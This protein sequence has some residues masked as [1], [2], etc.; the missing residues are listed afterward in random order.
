MSIRT[1]L[2]CAARSCVKMPSAMSLASWRP[3]M[4]VRR[5]PDCLN[6]SR[7]RALPFFASRKAEVATALKEVAPKLFALLENHLNSRISRAAVLG[8]I[9][10]SEKTPCPGRTMSFFLKMQ[11]AAL[12]LLRL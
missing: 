6:I 12:P 11:C 1:H 4:M 7:A 10:P 9:R 5:M 2:L 3:E 8:L